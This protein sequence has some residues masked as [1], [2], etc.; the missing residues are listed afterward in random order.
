M[1]ARRLEPGRLVVASH[2]AGKVREIT[3]LLTPF[4]VTPISAA[5]LGLEAPEETE[6]TFEG[7]ARIK[8]LA[9]AHGAGAPALADDSGLEIEAL[10]EFNFT[11][12]DIK[13]YS[14]AL[15]AVKN[16]SADPTPALGGTMRRGAP[17]FRA[18]P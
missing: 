17:S 16:P 13:P 15:G 1:T 14:A 5:E 18:S 12:F 2:N 10:G 8:A 7:N 4:G 11:A 3:E 6:T 9:S